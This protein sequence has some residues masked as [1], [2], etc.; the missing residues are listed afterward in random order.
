MKKKKYNIV[1]QHHLYMSFIIIIIII[2]IVMSRMSL[3]D[4]YK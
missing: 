1:G 3:E 4:E 2:I